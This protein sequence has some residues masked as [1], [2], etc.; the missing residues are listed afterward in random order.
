MKL[1]NLTIRPARQIK[2]KLELH[3]AKFLHKNVFMRAWHLRYFNNL[4]GIY[5]ARFFGLCVYRN[6][7]LI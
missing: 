7:E 6:N 5:S 3:S 4:T 2:H 1:F